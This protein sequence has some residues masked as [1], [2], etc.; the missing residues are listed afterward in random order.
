MAR[1]DASRFP[2][3]TTVLGRAGSTPLVL[4]ICAAVCAHTFLAK[5]TKE[6]ADERNDQAA[7]GA[8]AEDVRHFV[9]EEECRKNP[10]LPGCPQEMEVDFQAIEVAD[11]ENQPA[12]PQEREANTPDDEKNAEEKKEKTK[13]EPLKINPPKVELPKPPPPPP[14]PPPPVAKKEEKKK[15]V[16]VAVVPKKVE[17]EKRPTPPPPDKSEKKIAVRQHAAPEP[18][19]QPQRPL[20]RGPGQPRRQDETVATQTTCTTATTRTRRRAAITRDTRSPG[21]LREDAHRRE[22]RAQG[23]EEPR[24]RREGGATSTSSTS[25]RCPKPEPQ[26]ATA[27]APSSDNPAA[28]HGGPRARRRRAPAGRCRRCRSRR[29]AARR[30]RLPD[31]Q[32]A[33]DG[34]VERSTPAAA[35]GGRPRSADPVRA[36]VGRGV[37]DPRCRAARCGRCPASGRG[38][39]PGD[40]HEHRTPSRSPP[41]S[42]DGQARK[43][44][45]PTAS[46]ARASIGARWR[47]SSFERWR[48][49]IE[50]YV[51]SVKPGNQTALNT[52]GV[53]VRLLPQR[54]AQPHPPDL[55]RL[56]PR[57]AR[58]PAARTTR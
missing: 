30:R 44:R 28:A 40:Q 56:V 51:S 47:A 36:A 21:G 3:F 35:R 32:T 39:R 58:Q 53:P 54:D 7:L 25:R 49:A 27:T 37:G 23:G 8:M 29:R 1:Q 10:K 19:G 20:H 4:W 41:S 13:D 43:L 34:G 16:K 18:A 50:N 55:R 2:R 9:F 17:E 26:P 42:G 57:F 6:V 45:E 46:A 14:P 33:P 22:R 11:V 52:A 12:T 24:A 31:V 5:G 38:R 15:E 48:S